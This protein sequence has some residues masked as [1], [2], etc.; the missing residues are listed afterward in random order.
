MTPRCLEV[1]PIFREGVS[2]FFMTSG[3]EHHAQRGQESGVL[4]I[5]NLCGGAGGRCSLGAAIGLR[6]I[7]PQ[8]RRFLIG[9][10]IHW[11]NPEEESGHG[12]SH[13]AG[14]GRK[15]ILFDLGGPARPWNPRYWI[16]ACLLAWRLA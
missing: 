10:S 3:L 16:Y 8:R 11:D 13:R 6:W 1:D 5:G 9:C 12:Y 2:G 4:L 14:V 15:T 7:L